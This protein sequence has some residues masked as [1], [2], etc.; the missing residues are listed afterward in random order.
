MDSSSSLLFE[1]LNGTNW[2]SVRLKIPTDEVM[3]WRVELRTMEVQLTADENAA[4]SLL[5]HLFTRVLHDDFSLNMYIPISLLRENFA[6]AHRRNALLTQKFYFRVN[7]RDEGAPCIQ[8]LF[9]GEIF[10]GKGHFKGIFREFEDRVLGCS[11][12]CLYV[13]EVL[14][15]VKKF[16]YEKV[17]GERLTL[18]QWIRRFVAN[19]PA[20]ARNSVLPKEVMDDLLIRLHRISVGEIED[21]NFKR[22]FSDMDGEDFAC[23]FVDSEPSEILVI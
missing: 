15:R 7:M 23:G 6:R 16:L 10:F 12:D 2:N 1:M 11:K 5:V 18:A 4:F 13:T 21:D 9:I 20:Y 22:I 19:H 14:M 17:T 8:E 3:G